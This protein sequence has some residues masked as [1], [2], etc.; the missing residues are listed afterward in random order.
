MQSI[1]PVEYRINLHTGESI[2]ISELDVEVV[3]ELRMPEVLE[4][5]AEIIKL[6]SKM[7][8]EIVE[9]AKLGHS[10]NFT[11]L[12]KTPP[13]GSMMKLPS[14]ICAMIRDCAIADKRK[15]TT[16][17]ISNQIGKFPICW[18]FKPPKLT[19]DDVIP[20]AQSLAFAIVHAWREGRYVI[21]V[22]VP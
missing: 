21:L 2:E 5:T 6:C 4:A 10:K 11:S 17:N 9:E 7:P 3:E 18:E 8:R 12:M 15:C 16:R 1:Q 20:R 19:E 14:P 22:N 13:V